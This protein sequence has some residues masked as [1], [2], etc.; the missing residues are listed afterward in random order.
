MRRQYVFV[1]ISMSPQLAEFHNQPLNLDP[2]DVRAPFPAAFWVHEQVAWGE[3]FYVGP[4]QISHTPPHQ[5]PMPARSA[6]IPIPIIGVLKDIPFFHSEAHGRTDK[7]V[8]GEACEKAHGKSQEEEDMPA[9]QMTELTPIERRKLQKN[10]ELPKYEALIP[11]IKTMAKKPHGYDRYNR[12]TAL[13]IFNAII[14][15]LVRTYHLSTLYYPQS[16]GKYKE[17]WVP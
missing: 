15:A 14:G 3:N 4:I 12:I 5:I 9:F 17:W 2:D 11:L 6:G 8:H 1:N 7:E 13:K 10:G 16:N